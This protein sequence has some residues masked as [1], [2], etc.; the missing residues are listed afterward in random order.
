MR[1]GLHWS[2][3]SASTQSDS[4]T[5]LNMPIFDGHFK[6]LWIV[7]DTFF[8]PI[9]QFKFIFCNSLHKNGRQAERKYKF[10]LWHLWNGWNAMVTPVHKAHA[11]SVLHTLEKRSQAVF[12]YCQ[13]DNQIFVWCLSNN[14][15]YLNIYFQTFV[16]TY[17]FLIWT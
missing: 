4:Y 17:P 12:T 14:T 3:L 1:S 6:I 11:Y 5:G 2:T 9:N 15:K 10:A 13:T 8:S 16:Y 7:L